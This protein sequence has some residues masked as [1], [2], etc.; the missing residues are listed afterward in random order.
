MSVLPKA[1]FFPQFRQ[2]DHVVVHGI[3]SP[4]PCDDK[5]WAAKMAG[6]GILL[7]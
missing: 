7:G 1:H 5:L 6:Y 4:S 3:P 2:I